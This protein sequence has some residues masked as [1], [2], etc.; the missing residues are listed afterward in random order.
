MCAWLL[1]PKRGAE[2]RPRCTARASAAFQWIL[3]RY[4]TSLALGAAPPAAHARRDAR[5]DGGDDLPL[6]QGAEGI[7]S[8]SRTPGRL[9]GLDPGDQNTSFAAMRRRVA[10]FVDV[11]M[12]DPAVLL[13]AGFRG[14][15]GRRLNQG[16]MFVTLKPLGS[17]RSAPTRSSARLRGKLGA[18]RRRQPVSA[19]GAGHPHR[20]PRRAPSTSTRFQADNPKDL[21]GVGAAVL[22]E[23]A[24]PSRASRTSTATSRSRASGDPRHRPRDGIA[25]RHRAAADRQRA[26]RRVRPAAG[27]DDVH[28]AEPVPRRDGGRPAVLAES[29]EP[30]STST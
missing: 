29:R 25:S 18:V 6:R 27:L 3:G 15:P 16:R 17:A 21:A 26:L 1:K 12:K 11:V 8:R 24:D 30:R 28:A 10:A 20:R 22:A 9:I 4:E 14:R 2:A 19:G 23:A 13:R 7:L 5:D